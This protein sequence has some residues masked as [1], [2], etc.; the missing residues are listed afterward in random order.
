MSRVAGGEEFNG[1]DT[2]LCGFL[3][4]HHPERVIASE[5]TVMV[6]FSSS[7]FKFADLWGRY[8]LSEPFRL[9]FSQ[10]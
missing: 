6:R 8:N 2:A 10:R 5:D 7:G 3:A 4:I 9:N 1:F